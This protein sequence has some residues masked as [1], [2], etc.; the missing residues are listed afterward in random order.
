MGKVVG[1]VNRCAGTIKKLQLTC[2]IDKSH[3][4][5]YGIFNGILSGERKLLDYVCMITV[6]TLKK[7]VCMSYISYS[8]IRRK[9]NGRMHCKLPAVITGNRC[10]FILHT[11]SET[12]K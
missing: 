7:S 6:F 5:H 3:R 4:S 9:R 11:S 10:F 12:K 1:M 2:N 8:F